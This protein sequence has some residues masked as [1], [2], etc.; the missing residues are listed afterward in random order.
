MLLS[1]YSIDAVLF[2]VAFIAGPLLTGLLV[3]ALPQPLRYS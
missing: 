2:E 1:A 3:A